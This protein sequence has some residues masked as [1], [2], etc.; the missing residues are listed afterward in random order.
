MRKSTKNKITKVFHGILIVITVV[1]ALIASLYAAIRD[2]SVQSII[3]RSAAGFVSKYLKTDVKIRTFYVTPDLEIHIDGLQINDLEQYPM[4][5]IDQFRTSLALNFYLDN[6]H[7]KEVYLKNAYCKLATYEG[8]ELSNLNELLAQIPKK[9]KKET[10]SNFNLNLS[11]DNVLIDNAH[12][13]LWDQNKDNPERKTMDYKHMDI[14]SIGL[15]IKKFGFK[16][17]IISGF[18]KNL[19]AKERCGVNIKSFSTNVIFGPTGVM[20]DDLLIDLNNSHLDLDLAFKVN[21]HDDFQYF[22]DSVTLISNIRNTRLRLDDI[23][24]W[25]Y[26]L[27]KMPETMSLNT[28]FYGTINDFKVSNLDLGFGTCSN[29]KGS[30]SIKDIA[31]H[32]F[33]ESYWILDLPTLKTSYN[34]LVNFH[35]PSNSVTI[36]LPEKLQPLGNISMNFYYKGTPKE[37]D[38]KIDV[39]TGVGDVKADIYIL[40]EK[41]EK[42]YY[43]A[44]IIADNVR[45]AELVGSEKPL[46]LT[47]SAT[48]NGEGFDLEN[49]DFSS[50]LRVKSFEFDDNVFKDFNIEATMKNEMLKANAYVMNQNVDVKLNAATDFKNDVPIFDVTA[51]IHNANL[52]RLH[53][54]DS[55]STIIVSTDINAEVAGL[56]LEGL[57]ANVSLDNT[58]FVKGSES[59][60]MKHFDASLAD[61]SGIKSAKINC[62]FFDLQFDGIVD[63]STFGDAMKNTI[64]KHVYIPKLKDSRGLYDVQK[65]EFA[66]KIDLK[67]TDMLTKLFMPKLHV[68]PGSSL[69][70]TYTT[71]ES[72][73]GQNFESNEIRFNGIILKNVDIRNT[74]ETNYMNCSITV[75]DL[76]L[77]DSTEKNPDVLGLENFA[78]LSHIGNDTVNL[79]LKWKDDRNSNH[80]VAD[81]KTMFVPNENGGIFSIKNAT[82]VLRDTVLD[83]NSDSYINFAG[84]KIFINDIGF[85]TKT[86]SLKVTGFLP[87]KSEDTLCA[88]F[89]NLDL[90]DVNFL[91]AEKNICF[92]G[93]INGDLS[94]CGLGEQPAFTSNLNIDNLIVND[95]FVGD[96]TVNSDWNDE[97]Q[98]FNIESAICDDVSADKNRKTFELKGKYFSSRHDDNLDFR[99]MVN[100]FKLNSITPFV[101]SAIDKMDGEI[102]GDIGIIGSLNKP[103]LDGFLV[104]KDAGCKIGFLNTYYKINDTVKL[105][106]NRIGFD[107]LQLTDTT[108]HVAVANGVIKHNYLKDFDLDVRLECNDFAA[109]NIPAEKASGFYGSAIA[110]GNV[111]VNGPMNDIRLSID[112]AT[113]KGTEI[114]IPLSSKSKVDDNFIVFVH[115][116]VEVDTVKEEYEIPRK[117]KSNMTLDLNARVN[118]DAVL[119]IFLPSNMGQIQATGQGNVILGMK[120][121]DMS[122]NGNYQIRGGLFN[123]KLQVVNRTFTIRDGGTIHFNGNP[124]DADIDIVGVYRTKVS[125]KTLG[126][127]GA[128]DTTYNSSVNVD[129]TLHLRDKL[130]NPSITFGIE[131]PNA[132]DDIKTSVY[133][134][135][136]TT[137]QAAMA[138]HVLSLMVVGTFAN[139]SGATFSQLGTTAYYNVITAQL[140][141]WLSTLSKDFNIGLNYRP[142]SSMTNEEIEV[143]MST[144]LF[145]DRLTIEGNFGV[146]SGKNTTANNANNIVGDIDV[147]YK[148]TNRVSLKAYNHTNLN[149]RYNTYTFFENVS[150]YTQGLG[151]SFSQSF[152]RFSEI[153]AKQ[154][155]ENRKKEKKDRKKTEKNDGQR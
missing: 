69:T 40:D 123:F 130:M 104:F 102:V 31:R 10:N 97:D 138:Q 116:N 152:D 25:S 111:V 119:N 61:I 139:T 15:E 26:I 145:D 22:V 12:F 72:S 93:M 79:D 60:K 39:K 112:V 80:T 46:A 147:T 45:L 74:M 92:N 103:V 33:N 55:D 32:N 153:F 122:L 53:L 134:V 73:F 146:V 78:L 148:L 67:D 62:D 51:S 28:D 151:V 64:L 41:Y 57:N 75:D 9:E 49:A 118:P 24:Y 8:N 127:T 58:D 71:G 117:K 129:C 47:M 29:I 154:K 142:N 4:L 21:D 109:M 143:A 84:D 89:R 125:L 136:D 18:I 95:N 135:L 150:D 126:K 107:N 155:K 120:A 76:I 63:Y 113:R 108:G 99:F 137:N 140:N 54:V 144:Q 19:T 65:Q 5:K 124:T 83:L 38:T 16:N 66:L 149:S 101:A 35:I 27:S 17:D 90:S 52:N 6:L 23:K 20:L 115:K 81:I 110:N 44:T 114:N 87:N 3:A 98:S 59:Y 121:G 2:L 106:E 141:N 7:L 68:A 94:I 70:A 50:L 34:D 48:L 43:N 131:L 100:G 36:P 77:Q 37:L 82:M 132:K 85:H 14:D 13:I 86:Q 96:V 88:S 105:S 56:S 128:I 133:S 1:F 42:I 30:I 11:V 91:L